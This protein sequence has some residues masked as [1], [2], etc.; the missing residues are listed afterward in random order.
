MH[1][2]TKEVDDQGVHILS[3]TV[4][5]DGPFQLASE[6]ASLD[7]KVIAVRRTD[8]GG[9]FVQT[10]LTIV[11]PT[12][13]VPKAPEPVEPAP[14]PEALATEYL[15]EKGMSEG[16][17]KAAIERFGAAKILQKQV[18]ERDAELNALLATPKP[19]EP[20]K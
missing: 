11:E 13:E 17:A 20:A 15:K 5:A 2:T 16:E 9:V 3:S 19:S 10:A 4:E 8:S 14:T 18:A 6:K 12:P 1:V 7:A